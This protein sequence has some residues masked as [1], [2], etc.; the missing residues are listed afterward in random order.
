MQGSASK[1][2]RQLGRSAARGGGLLEGVRGLEGGEAGVDDG[3]EA[4]PFA[5]LVGLA[6]LGRGAERAEVDVAHAGFGQALGERGFGEARPAREREL[7]H[8]DDL[9]DAGGVQR[10]E[11][12]G[13]GE[14]LRSRWCRARSPRGGP[15]CGEFAAEGS[16][17]LEAFGHVA[18]DGGH[19][20]H[21]AGFVAERHDGEFERDPAAVLAQAGDGQQVAGAVAALAGFHHMTEAG[22][23]AGALRFGDDEVE[24]L[25]DG[26]GGG[27]A[28]QVLGAGVPEPD[29]AVAVGEDVRLGRGLEQDASVAGPDSPLRS[30]RCSLRPP[31]GL[32]HAG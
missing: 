23:V 24:R 6:A 21:L 12:G 17:L 8:V 28:E 15:A 16:H 26:F 1:Q 7:A 31:S 3:P 11:H 4:V 19:A 27:V 9:L 25:A 22:P 20:F 14:R 32:P 10:G 13:P 18:H 29:D 30:V 2:S 5:A